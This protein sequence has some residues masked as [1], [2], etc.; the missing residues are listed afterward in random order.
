ML[1]LELAIGLCEHLDTRSLLALSQTNRSWRKALTSTIFEARLN[2]LHTTIEALSFQDRCPKSAEECISRDRKLLEYQATL[3]GDPPPAFLEELANPVND[4]KVQYRESNKESRFRGFKSLRIFPHPIHFQANVFDTYAFPLRKSDSEDRYL[5]TTEL[6]NIRSGAWQL[7]T[8]KLVKELGYHNFPLTAAEFEPP[9]PKT[10]PSASLWHAR[11]RKILRHYLV[12]TS[13]PD[14]VPEWMVPMSLYDLSSVYTN[15]M[16]L[17]NKYHLRDPVVAAGMRYA[18][19]TMWLNENRTHAD[20]VS[21]IYRQGRLFLELF[22]AIHNHTDFS[23]TDHSNFTTWII[24]IRLRPGCLGSRIRNR[25][26]RA[27]DILQLSPALFL[28][29]DVKPAL[30]SIDAF[31]K[32]RKNKTSIWDSLSYPE[33]LLPPDELPKP[34]KDQNKSK[35]KQ[36]AS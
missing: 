6:A 11:V 7:Q 14:L 2:K 4:F 16:E 30:E 24:L 32:N 20:S 8:M 19:V 3:S 26:V 10:F 13:P 22:E 5:V 21:M 27:E 9:L 33:L 31:Y 35:K 29:S 34:P 25:R 15:I 23:L 1:P 12:A 36:Q 17:M 18:E 28:S